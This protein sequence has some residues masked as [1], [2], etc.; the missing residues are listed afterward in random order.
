MKVRNVFGR[1]VQSLEPF[2]E[3]LALVGGAGAGFVGAIA[4]GLAFTVL[5]P[6]LLSAF[7]PGLYGFEGS[8][9]VGWLAHLLHGILF[10]L[11]FA[12]VMDDPSLVQVSDHVWKS[13][14]A[15]IVYGLVL[16]V[17]GM[18]VVMPMWSRAV[19]LSQTLEVPFLTVPLLVGHVVF[20]VVL[21]AVFP[22]VDRL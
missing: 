5:D 4:M 10:G 16:A 11:G 9:A 2:D 22:F 17:V 19:G 1:R 6:A 12:V 7:I 13:V 14:V 15:G 8:L 18:G 20:G 3:H 21:G